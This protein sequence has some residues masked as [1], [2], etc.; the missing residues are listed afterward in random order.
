MQETVDYVAVRRLQDSYADIV[1]RRAWAE[2]HDIF[3]P[4]ID[5]V[6]DTRKGD[7][8]NAYGPDQ[9]S[10]FIDA[11]IA[12]F[13][14]FEFVILNALGVAAS[15]RR[16]RPRDRAHV[17]RRAASRSGQ[18]GVDH[19]VRRVPRPLRPHRRPLVVRA[20]ALPLARRARRPTAARSRSRPATCSELDA[21]RCQRAARRSAR[22]RLELGQVAAVGER[23]PGDAH[24][25]CRPR[26]RRSGT[27]RRWSSA[28]APSSSSTSATTY[29]SSPNTPGRLGR[30]S[31]RNA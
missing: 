26:R 28:A 27:R 22:S 18:R 21:V 2:F 20:A 25:A 6:L 29:G 23:L 5:V 10:G 7:L 30:C 24:A 31:T 16:R 4:D 8:I 19:V 9:V 1:T 11:A 3:V 14:F 17:H 13:D 15:R 12:R